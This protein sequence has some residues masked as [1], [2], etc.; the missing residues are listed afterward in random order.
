MKNRVNKHLLLWVYGAVVVIAN[1]ITMLITLYCAY[2]NDYVFYV[3]VNTVGEFMPEVILLST[4]L[5]AFI[6]ETIR[7]FRLHAVQ[8]RAYRA[9]DGKPYRP[10]LQ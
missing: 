4:G 8:C 7:M 3:T 9:S 2:L 6:Y 10:F 5:V 1:T